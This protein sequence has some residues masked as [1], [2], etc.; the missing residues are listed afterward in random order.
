MTAFSAPIIA[1]FINVQLPYVIIRYIEFHPNKVINAKSV[2]R[3]VFKL[4][5]SKFGSGKE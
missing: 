5:P 1:K 2:K 4:G 3:N